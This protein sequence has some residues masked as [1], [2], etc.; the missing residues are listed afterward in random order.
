MKSTLQWNRFRREYLTVAAVTVVVAVAVTGTKPV[1][2]QENPFT[3]TSFRIDAEGIR[4][5]SRGFEAG[6]RTH[7]HTHSDQLLVVREGAL[8][9][10]VEGQSVG[11]VGLH[12]TAYLPRGVRH[13]HGATPN[14]ALTHVSVTFPNETGEHLAI[15][16]MEPVTDEQYAAGAAR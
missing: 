11:E 6:A 16:W 1:G 4:V 2:G 15:E 13:W 12:E 10:Q 5:S 3:G 9:Y 8:R 7:W 14:E